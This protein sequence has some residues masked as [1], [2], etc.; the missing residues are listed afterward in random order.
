[1]APALL[2]E[3]LRRLLEE[4]VSIRPLRTILEG[5][6]EAGGGSRGAA[7]LVAAARRALRRQIGH[8]A[9]GGEG[10]ALQ[11][12]LLDPAAEQAVR[13][14]L[15]GEWPALDPAR[16]ALLLETLERALLEAGGHPVL[17]A[18]GDVRRAVRLLVAPRWPRLQVLSYD[19][20]PPEQ[21]IRPVG[22]LVL[23]A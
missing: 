4:G 7:L 14:S 12:L 16:A 20:L 21:Q 2:A 18:S 17:L 11:A 9:G 6:L 1:V 5:L 3:V 10:D 19:E 13:E 23:A 22:R 8:R 15:L